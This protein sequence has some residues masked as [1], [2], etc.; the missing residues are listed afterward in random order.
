MDY[1]YGLSLDKLRLLSFG[2]EAAVAGNNYHG[3]SVT[4]SKIL[5]ESS[6]AGLERMENDF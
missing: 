2:S 5:A 4:G 1:K 6:L 3:E